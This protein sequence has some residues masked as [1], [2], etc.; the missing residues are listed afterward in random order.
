M[1]QL[2]GQWS[3]AGRLLVA[4][5]RVIA[6]GYQY[7]NVMR[8]STTRGLRDWCWSCPD[9]QAAACSR[10]RGIFSRVQKWSPDTPWLPL[11]DVAAAVNCVFTPRNC[12]FITIFMPIRSNLASSLSKAP[13]NVEK[14]RK[15]SW[16]KWN[17]PPIN[18]I[19]VNSSPRKLKNSDL[20]H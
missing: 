13:Q 20:I 14:F 16:L 8:I 10:S 9:S 7:R 4:C 6:T 12:Q 3:I 17:N 5:Q 19:Q 15:M 2:C 11:A 18:S 1:D